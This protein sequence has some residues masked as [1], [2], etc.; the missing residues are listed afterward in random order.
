MEGLNSNE[1]REEEDYS[2]VLELARR[3]EEIGE[4]R[5][6][7]PEERIRESKGLVK[8]LLVYL[9]SNL[10]LNLS[11]D[12]TSL[13][14]EMYRE[15]LLARVEKLPNIV[16]CIVN[17][18]PIVVGA[19]NNRKA[20][21]VTANA[22]GLRIAMAEGAGMG[23][24][25]LLMG[26]DVKSLIGFTNDHIDVSEIDDPETDARDVASR[27]AYCRHITGEI[28][29]DDIKYMTM[30]IPRNFFPEEDL[31]PEE[32]DSL[33]KFIFRGGKI[34]A[35]AEEESATTSEFRKAA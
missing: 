33:A 24:V 6:L 23:P 27:K 4:S 26:L 7:S 12:V 17:G 9:D 15:N 30:R 31:S 5:T 8:E 14:N 22:E 2:K 34:S 19:G 29:R 3:L 25:R 1:T 28:H 20:N 13:Y 11:G 16:E 21:C 18:K 10:N 35:S 32:R